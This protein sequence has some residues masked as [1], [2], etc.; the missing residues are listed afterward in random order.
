[1][2]LSHAVSQAVPPG[3][4]RRQTHKHLTV[5]AIGRRELPIKG[6]NNTSIPYPMTRRRKIG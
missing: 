5:R 1:M 6:R 2:N 4:E 3:Q